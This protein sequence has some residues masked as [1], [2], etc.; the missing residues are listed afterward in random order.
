M[1]LNQGQT[2]FFFAAAAAS[3]KR[4]EQRFRLGKKVVCP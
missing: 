2:T 4:G 3:L 1:S